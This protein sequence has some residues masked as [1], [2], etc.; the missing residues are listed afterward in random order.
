MIMLEKEIVGDIVCEHCGTTFFYSETKRCW[1]CDE[2]ACPFCLTA[3]P[4][5]VCPDCCGLDFSSSLAPML[6]V[7]SELPADDAAWSFEFKWDGV[8]ALCFWDGQNMRLQSRNLL[9]ITGRYPELRDIGKSLAPCRTVF[10]GEIVALDSKGRPS[11]GLLQKRMHLAPEKALHVSRE[12]PAYY[13]IFDLLF[14]GGFDLTKRPYAERRKLLESLDFKHPYCLIPP[15]QV[16][17]GGTILEVAAAHELEGVVAKR[18]DSPYFP[19]RRSALWRKIKISKQQ[20]FVIGGWRPQERDADRVGS[21]LLGYY[22]SD[23]QLIYAGSVGSGFS[24]RDHLFLST[25]LRQLQRPQFPFAEMP[26]KSG[27]FAVAPKMV[28][29]VAYRR[30]PENGFL[31]QASYK[32]LRLDKPTAEVRRERKY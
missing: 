7:L 6:A 9:N 17:D 19:G 3:G 2:P 21:L 29:E 25:K 12:V 31:Q 1:Q 22:T 26:S 28:A 5:P 23:L 24:D 27:A 11:F 10:D 30:W 18:L 32:G 20:E 15:N 4:K 13:Y 8:R 14:A 16:G